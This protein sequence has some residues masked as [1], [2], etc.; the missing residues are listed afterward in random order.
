MQTQICIAD[1]SPCHMPEVIYD[2]YYSIH[3]SF[4]FSLNNILELF[5]LPHMAAPLF[6][7]YSCIPSDSCTTIHLTSEWLGIEGLFS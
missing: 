5:L 6:H 1:L 2:T 7:F 4:F 3:C